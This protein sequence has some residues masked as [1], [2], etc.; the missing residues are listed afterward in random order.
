MD[1]PV[2]LLDEQDILFG[3][4][5]EDSVFGQLVHMVVMYICCM[6]LDV[7]EMDVIVPADG[8]DDLTMSP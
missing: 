7:K 8:L 5:F 1:E 3:F 6:G 2:I 4:V